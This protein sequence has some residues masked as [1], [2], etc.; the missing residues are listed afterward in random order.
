MQKRSPYSVRLETWNI[1]QGGKT[2]AVTKVATRD[3]LGRLH[4]ATNFRGTVLSK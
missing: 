1:K 2:V 3:R 4:S